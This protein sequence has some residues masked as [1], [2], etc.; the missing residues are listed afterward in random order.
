[1]VILAS[2]RPGR[3]DCLEANYLE[4]ERQTLMYFSEKK[5]LVSRERKFERNIK[6]RL[7]GDEEMSEGKCPL[8]RQLSKKLK[9]ILNESKVRELKTDNKEYQQESARTIKNL[10]L[11]KDLFNIKK[12]MNRGSNLKILIPS[13]R[14]EYY[15]VGEEKNLRDVFKIQSFEPPMSCV[16]DHSSASLLREN[17]RSTQPN[18]DTEESMGRK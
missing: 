8:P 3:E 16:L 5:S 13:E 10:K 4:V 1:L 7:Q 11:T 9:P 14:E 15:R 18:L 2:G 17:R 12:R 6:G